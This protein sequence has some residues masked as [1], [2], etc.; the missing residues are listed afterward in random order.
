MELQKMS[1]VKVGLSVSQR[2][3]RRHHKNVVSRLRYLR[4]HWERD[5]DGENWT[6]LETRAAFLLSD[7]CAALDLTESERAEVL[8]ADGIA[9][10][11]GELDTKVYPALNERQ[12]TAL[13]VAERH[14]RVTLRTFRAVCP[15][16]SDETYRLDLAALVERGLL[17]KNGRKRGTSYTLACEN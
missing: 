11:V 9:A 8:G 2:L 15:G 7:V 10:L 6:A 5:M 4:E 16:W 17:V 12:L 14:E 3:A 13:A 1:L